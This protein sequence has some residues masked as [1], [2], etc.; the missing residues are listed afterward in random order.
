MATDWRAVGESFGAAVAAGIKRLGL[1]DRV[2][3]HFAARYGTCRVCK[4][5]LA[6]ASPEQVCEGCHADETLGVV[7]GG[8]GGADA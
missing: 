1:G 8:A 6:G 7:L 2:R 3:A 5:P 4:E